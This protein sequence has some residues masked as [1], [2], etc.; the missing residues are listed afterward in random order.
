MKEN[1][2]NILRPALKNLGLVGARGPA[3][4]H[5]LLILLIAIL[6]IVAVII[7]FINMYEF[8]FTGT[9]PLC[10]KKQTVN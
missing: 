10:R 4:K 8:A 5:I 1:I 7:G 6:F 9:C 2:E 3:N